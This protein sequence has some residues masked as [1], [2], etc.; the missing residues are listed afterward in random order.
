MTAIGAATTGICIIDGFFVA[1]VCAESENQKSPMPLS[2]D[3]LPA[4]EPLGEY[5][6]TLPVDLA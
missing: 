1:A 5:V 4:P 3:V 6:T 2:D